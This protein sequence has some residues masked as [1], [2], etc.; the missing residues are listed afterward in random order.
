MFFF[1]SNENLEWDSYDVGVKRYNTLIRLG[2]GVFL[3]KFNFNWMT[4]GTV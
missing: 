4:T 2:A 3:Y 1:S